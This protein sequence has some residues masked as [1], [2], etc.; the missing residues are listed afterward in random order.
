MTTQ[1]MTA[2]ELNANRYVGHTATTERPYA[3]DPVRRYANPDD[4]ARHQRQWDQA[5]AWD[6]ENAK[7][8]ADRLAAVETDREA[9]AERNQAKARADLEADVKRRFMARG[10]VTEN[11]W[12][13]LKG[14]L[15]DREL[16]SAP[17]PTEV[18]KARLLATGQYP[19]F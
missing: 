5:K 2:D 11:D 12:E 17:N 16:V 6:D 9:E 4:L 13:R 19:R 1:I 15:I 18:E 8:R 14:Q 10:H 3:D 7:A